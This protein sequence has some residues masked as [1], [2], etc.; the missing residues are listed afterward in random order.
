MFFQSTISPKC[1]WRVREDVSNI[2]MSPIS[3]MLPNPEIR[4]IDLMLG[5]SL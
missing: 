5:E 1:G 4:A 2:E 3:E